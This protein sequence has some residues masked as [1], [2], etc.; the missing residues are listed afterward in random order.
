MINNKV[1][2]HIIVNMLKKK[3]RQVTIM[4]KNIITIIIKNK[5]YMK[6]NNLRLKIYK[7]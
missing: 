6:N 4:K 2:Y 1:Y 3:Y 7:T 5:V